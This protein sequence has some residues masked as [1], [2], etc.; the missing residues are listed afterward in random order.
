[1]VLSRRN[2]QIGI[3]AVSVTACVPALAAEQKDFKPDRKFLPKDL[4][5]N[6]HPAGTIVVEARNQ[7]LY[8]IT[9]SDRTRH[10]GAQVRASTHIQG[11]SAVRFPAGASV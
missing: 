5:P 4:R 3:A 10:Y 1:M 9:K 2:S 6:G 8:L 7:F 11:P